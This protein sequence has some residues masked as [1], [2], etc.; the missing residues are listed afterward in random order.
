MKRSD[1]KF[2][3]NQC[4]IAIYLFKVLIDAGRISLQNLSYIW[5]ALGAL[6]VFSSFLYLDWTFA[7]LNLPYQFD[8]K[9]EE[10]NVSS[11]SVANKSIDETD[12][13]KW[14]TLILK[15]KGVW[16]HLTS[17]LYI[18]VVLFLSFL[19]LPGIFL[20]VTW[21]PWVLHITNDNTELS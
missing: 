8:T 18:L 12:K 15:R 16:Q 14:Y 11:S 10:K 19:L 2:D 4:S 1:R 6:L 13:M 7:I 5:L 9:L 3:S 20:A 17:P 21:Y